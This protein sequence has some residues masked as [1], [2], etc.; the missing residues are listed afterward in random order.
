M[1]ATRPS[2]NP[3]PVTGVGIRRGGA[4]FESISRALAHSAVQELAENG[5]QDFAPSSV[6]A[7]AGVSTRTAFRH[8]PTKVELAVAGIRS[9][10]TYEGWL[11]ERVPGESMADRL[12]RGLLIGADHPELLAPVLATCIAHRHTQGELLATLRAHVLEPRRHAIEAF[13][14]EGQQ[15]GE[16]RP[17]VSASAMAAADLGTFT[18][19]AIG[20]LPLGRGQRRVDRLFANLWPLIA[21]EGHLDD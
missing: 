15:R 11:S 4:Q 8:Y 19:S 6:A 13:L 21:A 3:S 1:P 9:L 12:R 14:K 17:S 2:R 10:P 5:F 20:Q 16:I 7:R 18:A